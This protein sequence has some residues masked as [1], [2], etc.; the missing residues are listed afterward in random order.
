LRLE[1][2]DFLNHTNFGNPSGS[3]T[4]SSF[5]IISSASNERILQVAVKYHF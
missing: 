3:V 5:G 1:A 4:S 2:F